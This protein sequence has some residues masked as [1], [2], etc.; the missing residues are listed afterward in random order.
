MGDT[1]FFRNTATERSQ[2][3]SIIWKTKNN[4]EH[5]S[6]RQFSF[7]TLCESYQLIQERFMN[8][9]VIPR[10]TLRSRDRDAYHTKKTQ[11]IARDPHT[12]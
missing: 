4:L 6:E 7:H 11:S 10:S 9:T 8:D 12:V 2:F 1:E 5:H 3:Q